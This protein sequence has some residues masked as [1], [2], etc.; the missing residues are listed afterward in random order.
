MLKN[1]V[2]SVHVDYVA[3][4][5]EAVAD[6]INRVVTSLVKSFHRQADEVIRSTVNAVFERLQKRF[7]WAWYRI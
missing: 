3:A 2:E 1:E 6:L 4:V 5:E 7:S